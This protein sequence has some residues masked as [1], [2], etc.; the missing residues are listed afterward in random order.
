MQYVSPY[1]TIIVMY[2][3][4]EKN[5]VISNY[6]SYMLDHYLALNVAC[7]SAGFCGYRVQPVED[8]HFRLIHQ[9]WVT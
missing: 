3:I 5:H 6:S 1:G 2:L 8:N 4:E 9:V 7:G